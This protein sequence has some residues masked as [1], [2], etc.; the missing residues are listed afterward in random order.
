MMKKLSII[1]LILFWA[2]WVGAANYYLRSDGSTAIGSTSGCG[3]ANTAANE[4]AH[5]GGSFLDND[6]IY[7]CDDGGD[8]SALSPP[9]SGTSGNEI[10]YQNASGDTPV[11]DPATYGS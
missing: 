7:L 2:S 1:L 9:S 11:I 10:I 4:A 5:N 8:F 3:A 6:I